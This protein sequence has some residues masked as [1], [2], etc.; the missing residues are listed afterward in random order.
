M[1]ITTHDHPRDLQHRSNDYFTINH[2]HLCDGLR[3]ETKMKKKYTVDILVIEERRASVIIEA[4]N[5]ESARSQA[6]E[7]TPYDDYEPEHHGGDVSGKIVGIYES[8]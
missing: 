6:E 7:M 1:R 5:E 8:K 4:E 2:S 3:G